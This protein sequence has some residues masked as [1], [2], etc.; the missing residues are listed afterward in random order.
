[1]RHISHI[2]GQSVWQA[3]AALLSSA[4]I[5]SGASANAAPKVPATPLRDAGILVND[6]FP[7]RS[8]AD[9]FEAAI[10][11]VRVSGVT[12]NLS[13]LLLNDVKNEDRVQSAISRMGMDAV[14]NRVIRAIRTAQQSYET[15]WIDVLASVYS[16]HF[17]AGQLKS[18]LAQ[19]E[20]SPHFGRLL[21]L[22][23]TIASALKTEGQLVFAQ[24]RTDVMGILDVTLAQQSD[25]ADLAP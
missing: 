12:K 23:E 17:S 9:S 18:I 15:K 22:Q 1:M 2:F 19:R 13:L 11:F 7:A 10:E 21:N 3:T 20:A 14:Q 6:Q 25:L 5:A 8:A 24:A 4:I 16:Q